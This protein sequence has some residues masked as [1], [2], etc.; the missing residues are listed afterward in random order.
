MYPEPHT[1]F[2]WDFLS[3]VNSYLISNYFLFLK[4]LILITPSIFLFYISGAYAFLAQLTPLLIFQR[5]G[6]TS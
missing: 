5:M 6:K 3:S 4:G 1:D 2:S